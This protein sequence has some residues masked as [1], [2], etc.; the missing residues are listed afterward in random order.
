MLLRPVTTMTKKA[1]QMA[2]TSWLVTLGALVMTRRETMDLLERLEERG[3]ETM[4]RQRRPMY[5][6]QTAPEPGWEPREVEIELRPEQLVEDLGLS[7][8]GQMRTVERKV[9]QLNTRLEA[10]IETA[11]QEAERRAEEER[12]E[13]ERKVAKRK[14]AAE[15]REAER[16]AAERKAEAERRAAERKAE[17][18]RLPFR[19][20]DEMR[21]PD[22][23]ARLP[24]LSEEELEQVRRY[25]QAHAAHQGVLAAVEE[26]LDKRQP[27]PAYRT[28]SAA[29]IMDQVATVDVDQVLKVREY[30]AAHA[31]RVTVIR[32]ADRRLADE[33]GMTDYVGL[34]VRQVVEGLPELSD[35]NVAKVR[36][37]EEQHENRLG[38]LRAIDRLLADRMPL[39][40]YSGL[41]VDEIAAQVEG[42]DAERL[43]AVRAYEE[44]HHNRVTVLRAVDKRLA[45]LNHPEAQPEE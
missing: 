22:I 25:E 40:N 26:Q 31:N 35:E 19:G 43:Q 4:R 10:T 32:A 42:L 3:E 7:T 28:L 34:T 14:A 17:A 18:E 11:E 12:R 37:F 33:I 15:R 16:Q 23:L 24:E 9:D 45:A 2:R 36:R 1:V 27:L 8:G 13:A 20:Y 5:P 39:P 38:V 21:V 41:T 6:P 44:T 30:E 29:Q